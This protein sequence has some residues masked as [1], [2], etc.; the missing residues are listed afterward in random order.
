MPRIKTIVSNKS[1]L[2]LVTSLVFLVAGLIYVSISEHPAVAYSPAY[3]FTQSHCKDRVCT[4]KSDGVTR[5]CCWTS[6]GYTVCQTCT[7]NKNTGY[8]GNCS[9]TSNFSGGVEGT[10]T[11]PPLVAPEPSPSTTETC[12][13]NTILG[14]RGNCIPL[15]KE[16]PSTDLGTIQPPPTDENKPS[17]HKLPKGD[18]LGELPQSGEELTAKKKDNKDSS[19]TPPPCP[20]DNSPIPPDCTLKPKF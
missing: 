11:S 1:T 16:P 9:S 12:P 13:E 15:T 19:P 3:C 2:L 7:L 14:A 20:T 4:D 5:T 18:I 10:D 17:K 6:S 8:Y